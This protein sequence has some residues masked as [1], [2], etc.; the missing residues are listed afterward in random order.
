M[1]MIMGGANLLVLRVLPSPSSSSSSLLVLF[2]MRLL[3]GLGLVLS[4]ASSAAAAGEPQVRFACDT[5]LE[6]ND[7][8]VRAVLYGVRNDPFWLQIQAAMQQVAK[9]MK[10]NLEI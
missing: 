9:D 6:R 7:F 2:L 5:C 10:I 4:A 1:S 8:T 3:V